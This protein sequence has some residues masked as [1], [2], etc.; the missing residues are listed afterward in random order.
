MSNA[1]RVPKSDTTKTHDAVDNV[2]SAI[3]GIHGA[4]EAIRGTFNQAVDSAA[5]DDLSEV[6][7]A[8]VV[9][10][11]MDEIN[12]GKLRGH[13]ARTGETVNGAV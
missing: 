11:G 4:G 6:K 1:I 3:A 5:G 10:K 9:N 7:D 12:N 2:K 13:T 8:S